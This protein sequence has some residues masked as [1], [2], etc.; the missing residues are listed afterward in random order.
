ML[1][2]IDIAK[3]YTVALMSDITG[4]FLTHHFFL[5]HHPGKDLS[6]C[7]AWHKM[8]HET[9]EDILAYVI[10]NISFILPLCSQTASL[11]R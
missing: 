6:C 2:A 3:V 4:I 5:S 11:K 8:T 7:F 9:Y 10:A 1:A